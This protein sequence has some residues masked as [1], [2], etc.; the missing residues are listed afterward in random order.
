MQTELYCNNQADKKGPMPLCT[1]PKSLTASNTLSGPP[2]P[3]PPAAGMHT[4][5]YADAPPHRTPGCSYPDSD[6]TFGVASGERN[7][8]SSEC[9]AK[10]A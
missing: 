3:R 5:R 7:R 4:G 6:T 9:R 10:L 1:S 8:R 2:A